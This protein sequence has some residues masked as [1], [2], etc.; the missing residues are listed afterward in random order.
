MSAMALDR[1][2]FLLTLASLTTAVA[3]LSACN[4]S[5][6]SAGSAE[7]A[8]G[9]SSTGAAAEP[10]AFPVT[11]AHKYGETVLEQAPTR[12]VTVGLKEQDDLLALG[13]V[14]VGATTWLT[15]PDDAV[16]GPWAEEALAGRPAPEALDATDGI[17]FEKIAALQP[18]LVLAL[19]SGLTQEQYDKLS[20]FAKVV[21][22]PEE[23]IDYGIPWDEQA[24]AVGKAVGRPATMAGLIE[25]TKKTVTDAAAAHPE[26]AGRT[27]MVVTPYEGLYVY[28]AE[29]PRVRLMTDLGFVLPPELEELLP[30]GSSFGGNVSAERA[31]VLDVDTLVCFAEEG[32]EQ[33]QIE[34]K[35]FQQLGVHAQ[36]R[37][38]WLRDADTATNPFS[39]LTVLSL[40]YLLESFV[41]R[42]VAAVDGDPGTSTA[43]A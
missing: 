26:F 12:I 9:G 6:G 4:A 21:A 28:G 8:A 2:R 11:L 38:V 41:P 32:D 33:G 24:A 19:Y 16:V 22:Q 17:P 37:T 1:R 20:Q 18:D 39:F 5:A 40:P 36:R 10:G 27:T 3:G 23:H 14:P 30:K 34:T 13:L 31:E 42:V 35:V 25:A 7:P 29:D 43:Q 15:L